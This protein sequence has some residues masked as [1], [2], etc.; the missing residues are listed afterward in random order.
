LGVQAHH[1]LEQVVGALA[2]GLPD[3]L[4]LRFHEAAE[5]HHAPYMPASSIIMLNAIENPLV[6]VQSFV[7]ACL[8]AGSLLHR[9]VGGIGVPDRG[10]R[11]G[12]DRDPSIP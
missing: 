11:Q 3:V 8:G 1:G 7:A 2:Y 9:T 12:G 4:Q 5:L 6:A 10:S